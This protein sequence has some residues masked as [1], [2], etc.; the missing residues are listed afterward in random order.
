MKNVKLNDTTYE[1]ISKVQ[2]PTA[3]GGTASFKDEDEIVEPVLKAGIEITPTTSRQE[4]DVPDGFDGFDA[5]AVKGVTAAIDP[6]I[7][8]HNIK[9]NVTIL[10]VTG[11]LDTGTPPVLD[12]PEP[13]VPTTVDIPVKPREGFDGLAE[14]MVKGVTATIDANITA[15]N[16]KKNVEILGVTGTFEGGEPPVPEWEVIDPE[17]TQETGIKALLDNLVYK[18]PTI[19]CLMWILFDQP[20]APTQGRN[21]IGTFGFWDPDVTP[22]GLTGNI[23]LRNWLVIRNQTS[24][25]S[26]PAYPVD[27]SDFSYAEMDF[28]FHFESGRATAAIN[29]GTLG[30]LVNRTTNG[31]YI[32][33]WAAGDTDTKNPWFPA[34]TKIH[35]LTI[36]MNIP[37]PGGNA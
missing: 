14:V 33:K 8:V 22:L 9:K 21:L 19:P 18:M 4:I 37:A 16:I 34:G 13:V 23:F 35:I 26:F 5:F 27:V 30:F 1:G 10:G 28:G 24:S 15:G 25:T 6:N 12:T 31:E 32:L 2:L 29:S 3:D 36:P 11:D 17:L 20:T 7:T